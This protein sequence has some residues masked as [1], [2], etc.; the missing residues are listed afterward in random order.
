MSTRSKQIGT[1]GET[2][3]LRYLQN[4]GFPEARRIVL[5]GST[6]HG[7]VQVNRAWIAEVKAGKSAE[8]GAPAALAEW[9]RE[10]VNEVRNNETAVYGILV[11]KRAGFGITRCSEWWCHVPGQTFV[12]LAYGFP[13]DGAGPDLPWV[14]CTLGEIVA[15]MRGFNW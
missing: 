2:A 10:L 3:T 14:T 12:H 7:D 9:K 5:H 13:H 4:N 6:D 1:A 11:R 15:L 8:V